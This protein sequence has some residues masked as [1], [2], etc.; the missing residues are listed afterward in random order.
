[1]IL[2]I[3]TFLARYHYALAVAFVLR[4]GSQLGDEN[5][6]LNKELSY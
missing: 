1:M 6:F 3:K 5:I 2:P 4:N